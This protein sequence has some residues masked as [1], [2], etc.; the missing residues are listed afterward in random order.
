[1]D[2]ETVLLWD[3]ADISVYTTLFSALLQAGAG[4]YRLVQACASRK[5]LHFARLT[6]QVR[7]SAILLFFFLARLQFTEHSQP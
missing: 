6:C 7:F 1:L 3:D 2:K 4:L 5:T